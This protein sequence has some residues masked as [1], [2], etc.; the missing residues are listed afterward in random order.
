MEDESSQDSS[1]Q[2]MNLSDDKAM[3][4]RVSC[5]ARIPASIEDQDYTGIETAPRVLCHQHVVAAERRVTFEAFNTG[6]RFLEDDNC[7]V[8]LWVDLEWPP[9][10]QNALLKLWEMYHDSKSDRRKDNLE[11]SLTIHHLTEE[12]K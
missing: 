1:A 7:G 3:H 6:R 8:V 5:R 11:S 12:K 2:Y 4:Y 10:L 9:T